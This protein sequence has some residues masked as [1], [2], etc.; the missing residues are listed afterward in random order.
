CAGTG[1]DRVALA[2]FVRREDVALLAVGV[3]QQR[4]PGSAVRVVLD[5]S[6][7]RRHAILVGATEVDDAEGALVSTADVAR[8][9]PA[10][11]VATA[12][13]GERAHERLLGG[14]ASHL[15]EVG[16]GAAA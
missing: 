13:L 9:D 15:D 1:L 5:V 8:R 16:D 2:Q 11:G 6:D 3:V 14:G 12:A 7:L 4:D 10:A